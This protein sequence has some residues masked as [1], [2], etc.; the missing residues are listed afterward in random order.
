MRGR[1]TRRI[2]KESCQVGNKA[3]KKTPTKEDGEAVIWYCI[4]GITQQGAHGW[5]HGP[6]RTL[7]SISNNPYIQL[8]LINSEIQ[9]SADPSKVCTDPQD[10]R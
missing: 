8:D 2:I 7:W 1:R 6:G 10:P 5:H 9:A 3:G 4:I